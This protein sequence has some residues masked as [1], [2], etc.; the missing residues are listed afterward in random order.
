MAGV[1][2]S[3]P[4][5]PGTVLELPFPHSVICRWPTRVGGHAWRGW[6]PRQRGARE[7]PKGALFVGSLVSTFCGPEVFRPAL[8]KGWGLRVRQGVLQARCGLGLT[9]SA[10][11]GS[12]M[13][14]LVPEEVDERAGWRWVASCTALGPYF[15]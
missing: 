4:R 9:W 2:S 6:K 8:G 12:V 10:L 15:V 1:Y 11:R 5:P 13:R 3:E 7:K 14:E